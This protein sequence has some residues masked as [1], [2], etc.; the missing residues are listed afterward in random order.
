VGAVAPCTGS[1]PVVHL[2]GAGTTR[3][4]GP[5]RIQGTLLVDGDLEIEGVV[6][7]VG[8]VIVRGAVRAG[9]AALRVTGALLVRQRAPATVDAPSVELGPLGVVRASRCAVATVTLA[10]SKPALVGR[11]AWADVTP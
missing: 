4:R 2:R 6:D 5:A 9:G 8:V 1:V 3:L 10:A 11:R 7:V